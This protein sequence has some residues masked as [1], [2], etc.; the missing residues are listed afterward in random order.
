MWRFAFRNLLTRPMRSLLSLLGLTVAIVGMVGLFSV[1]EGIDEMVHKTFK[2]IPGLAVLQPGAPIPIFSRLPK[3]WGEEIAQVEG[4]HEVN[5]EIWARAHIIDDQPVFNPPRFLFG[6]DIPSRLR[7]NF[8]VYR[9]HMVEGRFLQVDDIGTYRAVISKPIAEEFEVKVGEFLN[10]DGQDLE[11]VGIYSCGSLLLDVAI[12]LDIGVVKKLARMDG[13]FVSAFYVEPN[14]GVDRQ[15]LGKRLSAQFKDRKV[16]GGSPLEVLQGLS[17]LSS[18]QT[19]LSAPK[20]DASKSEKKSA[21]ASRVR[22][23]KKPKLK[24]DSSIEVRSSDDWAVEFKRFSADLDI[25]LIVLTSIGVT[26]AVLSIVNTMLMSVTERFIEFGILKANGWT[27]RNV[28]LLITYESALLGILGGLL[29]SGIGWIATIVVNANW[30]DRIHLYAS[31]QL[32]IFGVVFSTVL[33]ILGGLYPAIWASRMMPM[34]AIRR[35]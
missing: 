18:L 2:A 34:D 25:F 10:V 33:G 26:I 29:G 15:E 22:K 30:H 8:A 12:L 9:E 35:G 21:Q 20:Q 24:S 19:L 7:M 14:P 4:V 32:L 6:T 16:P 28:L 31:P 27:N 23:N 1:A 17:T 5:A 3:A 11:I 13:E